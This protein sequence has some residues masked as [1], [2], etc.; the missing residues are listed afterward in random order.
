VFLVLADTLRQPRQHITELR[1]DALARSLLA[2]P[3]A[4]VGHGVERAQGVGVP[5]I[6]L[7]QVVHQCVL[8]HQPHVQSGIHHGRQSAGD[9]CEHHRVVGIRFRRSSVV[10]HGDAMD[11]A[12]PENQPTEV[13]DRANGYRVWRR[14]AA[15]F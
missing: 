3:L 12:E 6:R 15:R 8:R 11:A 5:G 4:S 1:S 14:H 9:Q 7:H 10:V 13:H 2:A